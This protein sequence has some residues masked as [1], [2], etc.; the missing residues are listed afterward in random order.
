MAMFGMTAGA[1][2]VQLAGRTPTLQVVIVAAAVLAALVSGAL[3]QR[4]RSDVVVGAAVVT[5]P[6]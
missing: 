6:G 1:L 2:A 4:L 3:M 5:A